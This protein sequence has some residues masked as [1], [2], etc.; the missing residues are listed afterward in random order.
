MDWICIVLDLD[1]QLDFDLDWT[2]MW[3]W[4]VIGLAWLCLAWLG[5]Q[6]IGLDWIE[7]DWIGFGLGLDLD[8][9]GFGLDLDWMCIGLDWI[10]T[11]LGRIGLDWVELDWSWIWTRIGLDSNGSGWIGLDSNLHLSMI[12]LHTS[13]QCVRL[14][15]RVACIFRVAF[16]PVGTTT[17]HLLAFAQRFVI[18]RWHNHQVE[19]VHRGEDVA[20]VQ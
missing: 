5:L 11:G 4:I 19:S 6:W 13:E 1:L 3:I 16:T 15:L 2:R 9:T 12:L 18:I 20:R 17:N 7:M 8:R 14:L 10:W